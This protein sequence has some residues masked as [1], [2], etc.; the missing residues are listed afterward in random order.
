M[1]LSLP[2]I[3][4]GVRAPRRDLVFDDEDFSRIRRMIYAR[5]GIVLAEHKRDMVYSRVARRVRRHRMQR[6]RDYLDR[7]QAQP[8]AAEW[9]AFTNTLTT[10]L[11]AFFREAHHFPLL[12][13]HVRDR[14]GPVR[15]WSA[16]AS[17]GQEPYSIA[18]TLVE[19]LG[20]GADI[21]VWATDIDT[22]ALQVARKGVYPLKQVEQLDAERCRRFL[23]RGTGDLSGQVRVHP[24]LASRVTFEY[25][26]LNAS[27]WHVAE[28]F[29]A[30]F[31]RNVMIYFDA[32]AQVSM[33]QRFATLLKPDGLL[34]VGHSESFS[35]VTD[36]FRL[37]GR[38]VYALNGD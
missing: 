37:R 29:D 10:N 27:A 8:E 3:D 11:T 22:H 34:F 2:D 32:A 6:F 16:G 13:E 38:T 5:A 20:A 35:R 28:R 12:A 23:Q 1:N 7:L 21:Q 24:Q 18:M 17:T 30:I 9:K 19:T 33:L 4:A 25:L 26:N 36:R 14:R 15:V 31:C